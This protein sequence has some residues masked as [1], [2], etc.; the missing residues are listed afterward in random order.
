MNIGNNMIKITYS[1]TGEKELR[2]VIIALLRLHERKTK[3]KG[4]GHV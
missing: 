2:D 3:R 1:S 4:D